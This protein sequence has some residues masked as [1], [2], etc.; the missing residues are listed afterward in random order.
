MNTRNFY[1]FKKFCTYSF[2]HLNPKFLLKINKTYLFDNY[3]FILPLCKSSYNFQ[4]III[5]FPMEEKA[6]P[7][8]HWDFR[9]FFKI[10]C[11]QFL[12]IRNFQG[13]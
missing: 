8:Y 6:F 3:Y 13:V 5:T 2:T 10:F 7:L 4:A 11:I 12:V 1:K 9:F